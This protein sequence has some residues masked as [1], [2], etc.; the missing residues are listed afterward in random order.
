MTQWFPRA[1]SIFIKQ[2]ASYLLMILLISSM[3]SF[4]F[5][6]T[7]RRHFEEEIGAKLQDIVQIVARN[8]PFERLNLIR[9][10]DDNARIRHVSGHKLPLGD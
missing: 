9:V 1:R 2:L 5:F 6:S 10:G 4:M 8:T 3:I 7:A